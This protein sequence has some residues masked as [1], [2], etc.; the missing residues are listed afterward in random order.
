[1]GATS[2]AIKPGRHYLTEDFDSEFADLNSYV[3]IN[4]DQSL[5][6]DENAY[7][8][9]EYHFVEPSSVPDV[10][11]VTRASLDN[12][13]WQ[14]STGIESRDTY[15]EDVL[16]LNYR[17]ELI[18]HTI[19]KENAEE[20]WQSKIITEADLAYFEERLQSMHKFAKQM[21]KI[22]PLTN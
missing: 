12:S 9:V 19:D 18:Q 4:P 17:P 3:E 16:N 20:N 13:L 22:A 21:L 14:I 10:V 5:R 11:L 15:I 6:Q 1:L 7:R 2:R 8:Y